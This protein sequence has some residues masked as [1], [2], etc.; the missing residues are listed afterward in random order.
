MT[1]ITQRCYRCKQTKPLT[2]FS[3]CKGYKYNRK[4]CCRKCCNEQTRIWR[5]KKIKAQPNYYHDKYSA[6]PEAARNRTRKYRNQHREEIN[7][8][9]REQYQNNPLFRKTQRKYHDKW[10][11]QKKGT[12]RVNRWL[13]G[14]IWYGRKKPRPIS[15]YLK[16]QGICLFCGELNPFML[17]NAHIFPDNHELLISLCCNC[18]Y[19]LDH[20]PM[21][22]DLD[23][24][25]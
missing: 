25:I 3:P 15:G 22:L 7:T 9:K 16:G 2:E 17:Q 24:I 20:Y 13:Y 8:H 12:L 4:T 1:E 5:E 14:Y 21:M 19:L 11:N 18:H 23:K 10:Y 6:N